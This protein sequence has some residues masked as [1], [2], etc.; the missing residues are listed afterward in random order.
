MA[1]HRLNRGLTLSRARHRKPTALQHAAE[2][3]LRTIVATAAAAL[4]VLVIV[5]TDPAPFPRI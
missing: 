1:R 3:G 4:L 5:G 2:Q